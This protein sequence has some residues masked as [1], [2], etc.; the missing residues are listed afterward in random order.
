MDEHANEPGTASAAPVAA[1]GVTVRARE[2]LALRL[3]K[4]AAWGGLGKVPLL[5]GAGGVASVN[6]HEVARFYAPVRND[7][8]RLEVV[9]GGL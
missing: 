6:V 5:T 2:R 1:L 7:T 9:K 4:G 8:P 3:G